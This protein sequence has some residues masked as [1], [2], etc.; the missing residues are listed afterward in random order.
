MNNQTDYTAGFRA[1]QRYE[2]DDIIEFIENHA[3]EGKVSAQ[4]LIEELN[5]RDER[6]VLAHLTSFR[7][8]WFQVAK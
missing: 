4:L 7:N 3:E 8:K 6:D 5:L 2:R 1:G